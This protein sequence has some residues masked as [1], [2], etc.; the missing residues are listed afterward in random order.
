M[1]TTTL[2]LSTVACLGGLFF[3]MVALWAVCAINPVTPQDD[4]E[5]MAY[6]Q[7]EHK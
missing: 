3:I 6:L 2:I 4:A 5:Q 7:S 1:D